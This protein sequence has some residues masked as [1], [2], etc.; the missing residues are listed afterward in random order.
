MDGLRAEREQGITI[1]AAY[2][3]FGTPRRRFIVADAPGHEQYTRNMAT[4]ASTAD[5]AVVLVD[6]TKGVQPQTA[7]HTRIVGLF[8]IR[9]LLLAVNK[10][11]LVG[12]GQENF[13]AIG[14]A[15]RPIAADAGITETHAVPLAALTGQNLATQNGPACYQGRS[16][17][18]LLET[19][20]PLGAASEEPFRIPVQ[21]VNRPDSSFRGYCGRIASG[22]VAPGDRVTILPSGVSTAV[23]SIVTF[24]GTRGTA[25][26]GDAVTLTL[27]DEVDV[28]R[29]GII[30]AADQPVPTSDQFQ[31]RVLWMGDDP[32]VAGRPLVLKIHHCETGATVTRIKHRLDVVEGKRIAARTLHLNDIGVVTVTTERLVPFEPYERSRTL[33]GFVLIDP[34]T[35]AT[36]AGGM[37]DYS[38]RRAAN[39]RW[40]RFDVT[41]GIRARQKGQR[42]QCLW[43]TGLSGA[44]KS[45]IAN[46][47]DKRL[48]FDGRHTFVLDGD[49]V[50]HGLSGDLGFTAADR[51][52]NIRRA[53]EVARLTVD[54]GLIVI[55]SFISPFRS[56]RGL[57]RR[58]FAPDEFKE[59]SS[60]PRWRS[61][62]PAT[63]RAFTRRR[64]GGSCR[65]SPGSPV[66]SKRRRTPKCVSTP[67]GSR[68][69]S[70]LTS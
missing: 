42:A 24:G 1:D 36:V 53:A 64:A 39:L 22:S 29:G 51:V 3:N 6:A 69:R 8:G 47:L 37:I 33:G 14:A 18:E 63:R 23:E 46:L 30:G 17:L 19:A 67:T 2:V 52:E 7:R 50:R 21:F 58:L 5:L 62:R 70:A 61:A 13:D 60:T 68:P 20:D 59:V 57:A 26:R 41:P 55:V 65:I 34:M 44:G 49:N 28:T 35:E 16:L 32:L 31:A 4:A 11:D 9:H 38:L 27:S 54:A 43:M 15:F 10:M 12:W 25:E 56:E 45:T 66:P 40:E 48:V